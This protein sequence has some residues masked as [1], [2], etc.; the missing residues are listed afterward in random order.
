[1][2]GPRVVNGSLEVRLPGQLAAS[3][4]SADRR[5]ALRCLTDQELGDVAGELPTSCAGSCLTPAST[6]GRR[7]E[8]R[9]PQV[10]RVADVREGA[11]P[12]H[13]DISFV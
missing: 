8:L 3:L 6:A 1:V 5:V 2:S 12:R 9:P 11:G 4:V 10:A 13:K 7:L